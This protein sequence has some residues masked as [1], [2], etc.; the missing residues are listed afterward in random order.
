M[1]AAHDIFYDY[2]QNFVMLSYDCSQY[3]MYQKSSVT[4]IGHMTLKLFFKIWS[5]S[6]FFTEIFTPREKILKPRH[7]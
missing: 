7:D 5:K 6:N 2:K 4:A 3:Y 1:S